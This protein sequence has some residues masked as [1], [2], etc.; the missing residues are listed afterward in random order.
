[1]EEPAREILCFTM[2]LF[3]RNST[4]DPHMELA[5]QV[6]LKSKGYDGEEE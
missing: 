3:D 6:L 5:C 2:E 1:M 4:H